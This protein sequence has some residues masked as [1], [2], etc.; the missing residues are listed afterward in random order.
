M[1]RRLLFHG[2]LFLL[3]LFPALGQ[4]QIHGVVTD[5]ETGAP[6][7]YAQIVLYRYKTNEV[8]A[9]KLTDDK[10]RYELAFNDR[11]TL[12][13]TLKTNS[14]SH[15]NIEK[16]VF[17]DAQENKR[18]EVN[19]RLKSKA[20]VLAEAQVTAKLPPLIVKQ[21][22]VIYNPEYWTDEFDQSLEEVLAK[23]PGFEVLP[24][25]DLKVN[26]KMVNKVLIDGQEVSGGSAAL[27][28]RNL[29]PDRVK[30]VEVRFDEKD[31]KIKSSLLS[32][33]KFVVLDI[34]L[35]D[36]FNQTFFGRTTATLGH[37][38]QLR[39]G[40]TGRFFS[41]QNKV[42]FQ[43]LGELDDF[44]DKSISLA[45]I[46]NLG[47]E[48]LAKIFDVPADFSR[49]RENP[50]YSNEIYGFREYVSNR[51]A[52]VGLTGKI[53]IAPN[54]ELFLG[55][56]N[57]FDRVGSQRLFNQ[58]FIS[59]NPIRFFFNEQQ[60]FSSASS[61]N[62]AELV[63]NP[64]NMKLRYNFNAVFSKDESNFLQDEL[65]LLQ[66]DFRNEGNT[67]DFYHNLFVERR[68]S[69]QSGLHFNTLYSTSNRDTYRV[70]SHNNPLY[71]SL[72][73]SLPLNGTQILHQT[74]PLNQRRLLANAFYQASWK[75]QFAQVGFRYLQD[76]LSGE[77]EFS[78]GEEPQNGIGNNP[79]QGEQNNLRYRQI[80]PYI[81]HRI[82]PGP[83]SI[84]TKA[85][86]ALNSFPATGRSTQESKNILE[87]S[88]RLN[89]SFNQDDEL[90]FSYAQS[91]SAFPLYQML[92]GQ[93][94]QNFQTISI[95][96]FHMLAPRRERVMSFSA[97]TF[98]LGDQ[99]MVL[100]F[101][102]IS[103]KAFN[104]PSFDFSEYGFI[105]Q[106]FDQLPSQYLLLVGK[107]GKIFERFPLQMKLEPS[108]IFNKT[109]NRASNEEL[110]AVSTQIKAID[111]RAFTTFKEK[112]YDFETRIKLTQ[113]S[114]MSESDGGS[115]NQQMWNVFLK[116]KQALMG[117]KL[118]FTT[119]L[120]YTSFTGVGSANLF[121]HNF[122]LR[123]L[124]KKTAITFQVHNTFNATQ[125]VMQDITPAFYID[126]RQLIFGRYIK[127]GVSMDIN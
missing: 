30:S 104:N 35:K 22:T 45:D 60:H 112:S 42:R 83:I 126:S 121:I 9:F 3:P 37:Q 109:Y 40:G 39:P 61:K 11:N 114:F 80:L 110:T 23:I 68:F 56:F 102:G 19:I 95:P 55:S 77:K 127:A 57:Y 51:T 122:S 6:V 67:K 120:R 70:F 54:V 76:D 27:I 93:E 97:T 10:G 26:G 101:A 108:Y 25:G 125:F 96:D 79:W 88:A 81:E 105:R 103:G 53:D 123:Y 106:Y 52:S 32:Q 38:D 65:Q 4:I 99:G 98:A 34:K 94:L 50:E 24:N 117:R 63:V 64:K 111:Y 62:K 31:D 46:R 58:E 73:D 100:E 2:L 124:Y 20:H 75:G 91:T 44:G 85:G 78:L 36:D 16:D 86:L 33:D 113:F 84:S 15:E 29:S 82:N 66:Y 21:D 118:L 18:Y 12:A 87:W 115:R 48:A 89:Y 92:P 41:L 13:F 49:L 74:I 47:A 1:C 17:L 69:D 28:T 90:S 71:A 59:D 5:A 72:F 8:V 116:Y 14:L 119:D 7:E 107:V 43:L